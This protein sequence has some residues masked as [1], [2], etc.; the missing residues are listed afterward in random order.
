MTEAALVL[1]AWG[2][3]RMQFELG[4]WFDTV[5]K[6]AQNVVPEKRDN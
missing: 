2:S 6:P 5:L 4:L 3:V 1:A